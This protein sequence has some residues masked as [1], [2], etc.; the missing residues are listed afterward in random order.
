MKRLL[1]AFAFFGFL[2]T[3]S[4]ATTPVLTS[5]FGVELCEDDEK[6]SKKDCKN[7]KKASTLKKEDKKTCAK[8]DSAKKSCCSKDKAKTCSKGKAKKE[9]AKKK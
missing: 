9:A 2:A 3:S 5:I 1:L 4:F 6:C 7:N 8:G